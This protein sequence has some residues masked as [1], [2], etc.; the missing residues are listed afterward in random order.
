MESGNFPDIFANDYGMDDHDMDETYDGEE[1]P[2]TVPP[3]G[4]PQAPVGSLPTQTSSALPETPH[5]EVKKKKASRKSSPV[6]PHYSIV[7]KKIGDKIEIKDVC[8]HCR[9]AYAYSKS[10]SG[11]GT[12]KRHL[13]REHKGWNEE[14]GV[15]TTTGGGLIQTQI[16][17]TN[18]SS[19]GNKGG[20]F[21]YTQEKMRRGLARLLI[22]E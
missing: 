9:H 7:E 15:G 14:A 22:T 4:S 20:I 18:G 16:R 3:I 10:D 6:W 19:A 13:D 21:H 11:T 12:L 8:K 17:S 2:A 1:I 5:S